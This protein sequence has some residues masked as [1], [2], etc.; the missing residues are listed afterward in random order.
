MEI[1]Q[2]IKIIKAKANYFEYYKI[3]FD[4]YLTLEDEK[5]P[6]TI[7]ANLTYSNS[8]E[9]DLEGDTFNSREYKIE[10]VNKFWCYDE[11][12]EE[13][14]HFEDIS[15]EFLNKVFKLEFED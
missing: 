8:V 10:S 5:F 2:L 1:K 11:V 6:I 12:A 4:L 7:E 15:V 13:E 9:Y 3:G 14:Y